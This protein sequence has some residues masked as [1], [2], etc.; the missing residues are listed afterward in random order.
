M[1]GHLNRRAVATIAPPGAPRGAGLR[2]L[3]AIL[4][5][6]VPLGIATG[7][8]PAA[9][10]IDL[11]I[12]TAFLLT[13]L[14]WYPGASGLDPGSA[15]QPAGDHR[16]RRLWPPGVGRLAQHAVSRRAIA[17]WAAGGGSRARRRT[18]PA[19]PVGGAS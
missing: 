15:P 19:L 14:G 9:I 18:R 7:A 4:T 3:G 17:P 8:W 10:W 2:R 13:H 11:A 5:V 6:A 16:H 1:C 12:V